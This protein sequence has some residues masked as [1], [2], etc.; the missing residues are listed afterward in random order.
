MLDLVNVK[1]FDAGFKIHRGYAFSKE[2]LLL[3]PKLL[4]VASGTSIFVESLITS[5]KRFCSI[6][7]ITTVNRLSQKEMIEMKQTF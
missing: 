4:R 7:P 6:G 3:S 2:K 1:H 5:T